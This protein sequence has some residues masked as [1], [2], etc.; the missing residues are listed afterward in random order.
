[1]TK[2]VVRLWLFGV[3]FSFVFKIVSVI[4]LKVG[5]IR[6]ER[7]AKKEAEAHAF[8]A[9]I[10]ARFQKELDDAVDAYHSLIDNLEEILAN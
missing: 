4:A 5:R 7:A 8:M 10:D 9:E 6:L 3:L 1:M 2:D